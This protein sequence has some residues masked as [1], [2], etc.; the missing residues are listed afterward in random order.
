MGAGDKR[1]LEMRCISTLRYV[2]ILF[3]NYTNESLKVL[4]LR[5][6]EWRRCERHGRELRLGING[7]SRHDTS[8]ALV[9]FFLLFVITKLY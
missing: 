5:A 2:L 7:A 8:R 3:L 1:G 4:C 9:C 6:Y